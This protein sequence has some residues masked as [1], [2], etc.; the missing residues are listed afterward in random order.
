MPDT[1]TNLMNAF[2][3]ESKAAMKYL[4]YAAKADDEGQPQVA[5]LF[6]AASRAETIHA[7]NHLKAASFISTT[8]QNLH[9]A[10]EGEHDEFTNMYPIMIE[11]SRS[12]GDKVAEASLF[13]A[14]QVEKTHHA[15]YKAAAAS[16]KDGE[17]LELKPVYVCE[18]CGNTISGPLPDLCSVCGAVKK[19]FFE[20]K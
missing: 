6:R 13:R 12:D 8:E 14:N 16:I 5:K 17:I 3:G 7:I 9:D 20:I 19:A 1:K 2:G 18:V 4:V 11:K 15:M 10:I